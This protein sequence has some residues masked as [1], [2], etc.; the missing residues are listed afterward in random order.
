MTS[1]VKLYSVREESGTV[2]R[3]KLN[4]KLISVLETFDIKLTIM[5]SSERKAVDLRIKFED[6]SPIVLLA[7]RN[8][9][10]LIVLDVLC[11]HRYSYTT[12]ML[13]YRNTHTPVG[14]M[15]YG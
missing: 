6:G 7:K 9:A 14:T 11:L 1:N 3:R 8:E 12:C 4:E 13:H 5:G 2:V 10:K 15:T